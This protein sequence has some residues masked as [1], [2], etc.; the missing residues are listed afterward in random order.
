MTHGIDVY[1]FVHGV[2]E[3]TEDGE[4]PFISPNYLGSKQATNW[5]IFLKFYFLQLMQNSFSSK[6]ITFVVL[7]TG[8]VVYYLN[9]HTQRKPQGLCIYGKFLMS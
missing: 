7:L 1:D 9:G 4:Y 3:E 2:E 6:Y 5:N 8:F